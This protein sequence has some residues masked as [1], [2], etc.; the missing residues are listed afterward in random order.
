MQDSHFDSIVGETTDIDDESLT[1]PPNNQGPVQ[2]IRFD[3]TGI[4]FRGSS[5]NDTEACDPLFALECNKNMST[6]VLNELLN[7]CFIDPS[8]GLNK[9]ELHLV[10]QENVDALSDKCFNKRHDW[11]L[12]TNNDE[13]H[14]Y[15]TC[16]QQISYTLD[17]AETQ[18]GVFIR[19]DILHLAGCRAT[20]NS[21]NNG[22]LQA[23]F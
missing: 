8:L 17:S 14:F 22:M 1:I 16:C 2:P 21:I 20:T 19:R 12:D 3:P 6:L 13:N 11:P 5:S 18:S 4:Q 7:Y 15:Q 10:T 9:E 23:F